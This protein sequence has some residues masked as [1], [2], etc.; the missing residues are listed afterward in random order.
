MV[1]RTKDVGLRL[2]IERDLREQFVEAC[3]AE[4]KPAAYVLR[5]YMRAYV[6]RNRFVAQKELDFLSDKVKQP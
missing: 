3:R 4:G 2:R 6:A 5:E 1:I